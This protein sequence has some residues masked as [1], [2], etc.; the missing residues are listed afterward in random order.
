[1]YKQLYI[2]EQHKDEIM[3]VSSEKSKPEQIK[4]WY[5]IPVQNT[6]IQ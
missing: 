5:L 6:L 4:L 3:H 2:H 1:M